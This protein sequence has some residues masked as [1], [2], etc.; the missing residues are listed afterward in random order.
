M[1]GDGMTNMTATRADCA[2]DEV[3]ELNKK[4]IRLHKPHNS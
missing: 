3:A 4:V 2:S 1:G